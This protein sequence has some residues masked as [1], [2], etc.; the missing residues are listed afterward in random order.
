MKLR[1]IKKGKKAKATKRR[2]SRKRLG[3]P[4][5]LA[6]LLL[7]VMIAVLYVSS[8][9]ARVQE[10]NIT[11]NKMVSTKR[12]ENSITVDTTKYFL[13]TRVEKTREEV[14]HIGLIKDAKVTKT[15][16]GKVNIQ[17]IEDKV[18][19]YYKNKK[20]T[21]VMDESGQITK[22][23]DQISIKHIEAYPQLVDFTDDKLL[24]SFAEAYVS[25]PD[26]IKNCVSDIIYAPKP[27]DDLRI[28]LVMDDGKELV[29]RIDEMASSLKSSRFNYQA[30]MNEF[31][32]YKIFSFEGDHIYMSK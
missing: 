20:G 12:I 4:I 24:A 22:I 27:Q 2:Q 15:I 25:V 32:D 1:H 3:L 5:K 26:I 9:Y 6:A 10:V 13:L 8:G 31:D 29:I 16:T 18:V 19:A 7:C 21:F 17:V 30:Y 28:R 14:A 11:G 23:D